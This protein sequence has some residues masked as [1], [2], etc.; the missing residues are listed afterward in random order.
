MRRTA[1]VSS[2]YFW[3]PEKHAESTLPRSLAP[4]PIFIRYRANRLSARTHNA[5][6]APPLTKYSKDLPQ[7]CT[8]N[9][10]RT[11]TIAPKLGQIVDLHRRVS[12]Y[13]MSPP[14]HGLATDNFNTETRPPSL[15]P[16]NPSAHRTATIE[17]VPAD[18]C[19]PFIKYARRAHPIDLSSRG[20][21]SAL[22][23]TP[24]QKSSPQPRRRDRRILPWIPYPLLPHSLLHV[25]A[26]TRPGRA[27]HTCCT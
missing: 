18:P 21:S 5:G 12:S 6:A 27:T 24:P 15:L 22:P 10:K 2:V 20:S 4:T 25:D 23:H 13:Q 17:A 19:R 1:T 16:S 26:T 8:Q 3:Q 7:I 9:R 11:Q 14:P